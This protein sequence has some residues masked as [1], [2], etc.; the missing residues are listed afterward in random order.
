[1]GVLTSGQ[2]QFRDRLA[3]QTGLNP[4]VIT[5]WMLAEESGGAARSRQSSGQHNWLNI[6]WTDSGRMGLTRQN[7]WSNPASAADATAAFLKGQKYGASGGIRRI[8][9]TAGQGVD[10]QI[11]AIAGSGWASSGYEGGSTLKSLYNSY[12]KDVSSVQGLT[13]APQAPSAQS[14]P[15]GYTNTP[16]TFKSIFNKGTVNSPFSKGVAASVLPPRQPVS[17][18]SPVQ[19]V[20]EARVNAAS[21]VSGNK[22]TV[23]F[24]GTRVAAWIAPILKYARQKGWKGSINSGYRSF[25]DQTRIWNS[26][27]RPAARPGTSNHEGSDYPRGAIDVNG[28]DQL[29]QILQNSPYKNVLVWAGQKDPVHFSHP[30]DGSY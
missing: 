27:V 4:G 25:A 18:A 5:A 1:M 29:H 8:I 17:Q 12:G 13:A 26:G 20:A 10:A 11:R 24:E 14:V 3:Q 30:H 2:A 21:D 15:S 7:E 23:V 22:G 6:G 19:K 16:L 9:G 28:A